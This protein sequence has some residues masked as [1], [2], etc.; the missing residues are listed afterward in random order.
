MGP[1]TP[2]EVGWRLEGLQG[3]W[4]LAESLSKIFRFLSLSFV[5]CRVGSFTLGPDKEQ[6]KL[7]T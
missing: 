2:S 6:M 4:T 7:W 3:Q 1:D 5:I